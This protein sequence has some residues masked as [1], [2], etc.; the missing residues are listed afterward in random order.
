MSKELH[1]FQISSRQNIRAT[2]SN[3]IFFVS[4]VRALVIIKSPKNIRRL[5]VCR[6]LFKKKPYIYHCNSKFMWHKITKHDIVL[7]NIK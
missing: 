6:G 3:T 4:E 2:M 5:F 1:K 7:N